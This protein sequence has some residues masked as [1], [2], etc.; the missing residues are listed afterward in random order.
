MPH[1]ASSRILIPSAQV[2]SLTT[3]SVSVPSSADKFDDGAFYS[4]ASASSAGSSANFNFSSIPQT[5]KH[6]EIRC[7]VRSAGPSNGETPSIYFNN[8]SPA[9]NYAYHAIRTNATGG[10]NTF[11]GPTTSSRSLA[12]VGIPNASGYFC[13][14]IINIYDYTS[15]NKAKTV[16]TMCVWNDNTQGYAVYQTTQ[17]T[18]TNAAITQI[19]IDSNYNYAAGSYAALYGIKG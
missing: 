5:Y 11:A 1:L 18:G 13:A 9:T 19:D 10:G 4:I 14:M 8:I 17:Y 3:G 16:Q 12:N 7:H 2:S 6:L 15:A